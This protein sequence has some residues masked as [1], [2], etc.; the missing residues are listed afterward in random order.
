[1]ARASYS[2]TPLLRSLVHRPQGV[3]LGNTWTMKPNLSFFPSV[4]GKTYVTFPSSQ[5]SFMTLTLP[6]VMKQR[7]SAV[8]FDRYLSRDSHV[9]QLSRRCV[10]ILTALSHLRHYLPSRLIKSP[11]WRVFRRY[12]N[13]WGHT[14]KPLQAG[15]QISRLSAHYSLDLSNI[16]IAAKTPTMDLS[17]PYHW[18]S[19]WRS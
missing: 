9:E 13:G 3:I 1:M 5:W 4:L 12:P 17:Y 8:T 2:K 6:P 18:F 19:F 14:V 15:V 10:G 11:G 16:P 7:T